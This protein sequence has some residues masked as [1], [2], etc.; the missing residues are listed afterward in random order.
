MK[1]ENKKRMVSN[2]IIGAVVVLV[3]LQLYM[4]WMAMTA[5]G[6]AQFECSVKKIDYVALQGNGSC[7]F[8]MVQGDVSYCALPQDIYCKGTLSEFP[9]MRGIQQLSKVK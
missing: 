2:I 3:F 5:R 4:V 7:M 8:P 1:I 9:L 6:S